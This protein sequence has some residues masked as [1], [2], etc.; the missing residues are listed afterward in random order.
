MIHIHK[1]HDTRH[2]NVMIQV[3]IHIY[4][5]H[6]TIQV[7]IQIHDTHDIRQDTNP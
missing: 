2:D 7:M 3:M 6:D 4:E 5:T 1:T